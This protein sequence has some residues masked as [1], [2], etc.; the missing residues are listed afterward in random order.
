MNQDMAEPNFISDSDLAIIAMSCRVPGA[1]SLEQ[2][3]DN[4]Q[5]GVESVSWFEDEE[6]LAEGID[7][8]LLENPNYVKAGAV[9]EDIDKFDAFF[10]DINGREAEIIDPQHRIF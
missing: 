4:L 9:L 7:A 2:F 5:N 8:K 3:W 6:L 1:N 10:F